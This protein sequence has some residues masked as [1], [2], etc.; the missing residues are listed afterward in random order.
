[1]EGPPSNHSAVAR[2]L[3]GESE[4][5]GPVADLSLGVR[6][7]IGMKKVQRRGV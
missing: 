4:A 2:W 5:C 6:S 1:M 3:R 7:D